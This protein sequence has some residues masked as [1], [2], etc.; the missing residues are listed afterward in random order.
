MKNYLAKIHLAASISFLL[1]YIDGDKVAWFM[2][3]YL[4]I[5]TVFTLG[6]AAEPALQ[7]TSYGVINAVLSGVYLALVFCSAL[8]MLWLAAKR[9]SANRLA[10]VSGIIM[11]SIVPVVWSEANFHNILSVLGL[12]FF[13]IVISL[14]II[15]NAKELKF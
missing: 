13:V 7:P 12:I 6:G 14:A 2:A 10:I 4:P 5:L 15:E 8:Y 1:L 11:L 3:F 9:K